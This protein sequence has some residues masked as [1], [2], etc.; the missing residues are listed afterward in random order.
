MRAGKERKKAGMR[1]KQRSRRFE[2]E[3]DDKRKA[4]KSTKSWSREGE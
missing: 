3:Q 1:E 4:R 2:G